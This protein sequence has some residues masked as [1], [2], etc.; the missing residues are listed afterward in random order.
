MWP[1]EAASLA[2]QSPSD[3]MVTS[4]NDGCNDDIGSE[5]SEGEQSKELHARF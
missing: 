2:V 5:C 3:A 1:G 4:G